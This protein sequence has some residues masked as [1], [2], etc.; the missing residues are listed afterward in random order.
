[1]DNIYKTGMTNFY[2]NK[3]RGSIKR[4]IDKIEK[5]PS[6]GSLLHKDS[7][8]E[9]S[10]LVELVSDLSCELSLAKLRF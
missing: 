2:W 9:Y 3:V 10:M 6:S 4:L 7:M 1:M 5:L 8:Q